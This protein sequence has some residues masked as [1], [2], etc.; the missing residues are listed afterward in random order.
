[1]RCGECKACC[2]LFPIRE[3]DKPANVLCDHYCDGCTIHET[4]PKACVEYEC[5]YLQDE[6]VP[7]SLRP[8]KCGIV[9]TKKTDRIFSGILL[10]GVEV[11][12]MA[13]GQINAF[14]DQGYSVV[15]LS[16]GRKPHVM[17]SDGCDAKE[18]Y[19]E[20]T[21]ALGGYSRH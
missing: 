8:D 18:I 9:F 19:D 4:K 6:R 12:D 15:M 20:Y 1:M 21:G 14:L 2:T 3:L 17:A 16:S 10:P 11:S 13:K 7:E 5:A